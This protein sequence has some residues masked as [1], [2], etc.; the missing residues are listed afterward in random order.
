MNP[1]DEDFFMP[2]SLNNSYSQESRDPEQFLEILKR[3]EMRPLLPSVFDIQESRH[4]VGHSALDMSELFRCFICFG[5][6]KNA[7]MCPNCSKLCCYLCINKV[8]PLI[9]WLT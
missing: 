2:R 9:E 1:S 5:T 4:E 7:Q 6:V 8:M 3:M